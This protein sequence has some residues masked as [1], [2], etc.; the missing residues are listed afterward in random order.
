ME[1][2]FIGK[3]NTPVELVKT[4]ELYEPSSGNVGG[5]ILVPIHLDFLTGLQV[6]LIM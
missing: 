3:S 5:A 1:M 2:L 6:T 4:L